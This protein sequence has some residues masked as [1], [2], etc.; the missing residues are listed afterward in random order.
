MRL[1]PEYCQS[2]PSAQ[3]MIDIMRGSWVS[4]FPKAMGLV[5]GQSPHFDED[6]RVAWANSA[7][8][9]GI[10]GMSVLELGPLEAYHT[11]QME[12]LGARSVI[13]VESNNLSFVK[14]M[15]VK[16]LFKLRASFLYGDCIKYLE[17]LTE[18]FDLCW[19][20][21][22]LYH[23]TDPLYLLSLMQKVADTLFVWTH[24]YEP[25]V[26]PSNPGLAQHFNSRKNIF[27]EYLG[28]R[29]EY[30]YRSYLESKGAVFSGGPED[31]SYWMRKE[32]IF[33]FLRSVGYDT[34]TI[35][36]DHP[37]NPNGPAMFFLARR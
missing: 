29:V 37:R 31:F 25:T 22:L 30:F 9:N 4:S 13:S 28:Y 10:K 36:V 20:S 17:T 33:G 2:A 26:I 24:Y 12:G 7:L 23:Q 8:A 15:I 14:C 3:N 34:I 16:E 18:R 32:D 5:A 6:N 35:G 1:T 19:A 21:G 11:Y 27:A